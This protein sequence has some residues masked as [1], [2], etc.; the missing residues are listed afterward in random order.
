MTSTSTTAGPREATLGDIL[1]TAVPTAPGDRH[2]PSPRRRRSRFPGTG[3]AGSSLGA[4]LPAQARWIG[5]DGPLRDLVRDHATAAG[6]ELVGPDDA[7]AVCTL[8]DGDELAGSD[9]LRR[10]AARSSS[11][12]LLSSPALLVVTTEAVPPAA[13]WQ[14]ALAAGARAVLTLP[15]QSEELLAQFAELA[16]PRTAALLLGVVGGCGG[17]GASSLAARLAAAARRHGPVTLV[18]ADPLGGGLDLLVEAP[19]GEGPGWEAAAGLGAGDG[20]ALRAALPVVDEVHL[21]T[22]GEGPGPRA[23]DLSP[24]LAALAPLGGTVVVDLAPSLVPAIATQLDRLLMLVPAREHAVHAAA[25]RLASW[26]LP[27]GQVEL[28]V[29]RRGPLTPQD[30]AEDLGLPLAATF[31][32]SSAGTVPLLDVRRG[33]ADRA[34]RDLLEELT[35]SDWDTSGGRA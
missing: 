20:E 4:G 10:T 6:I 24:A 16:R 8:I 30:V 9:G 27:P 17:A 2:D 14:E 29:R 18:D 7:G 34:A 12:T 15:A 11:S 33:G 19:P 26:A 3:A 31:R 23:Q 13:L 32:N 28:V 21:L 22:A 5:A 35:S 1:D 25:R